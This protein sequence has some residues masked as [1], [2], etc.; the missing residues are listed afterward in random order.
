MLAPHSPRR[1]AALPGAPRLASVLLAT[2]LSAAVL[3]AALALSGCEPVFLDALVAD[4]SLSPPSQSRV[5]WVGHPTS[6]TL[7]LSNTSRVDLDLEPP[8]L[9]DAATLLGAQLLNAPDFVGSAQ[10]VPLE[11]ALSPAVDTGGMAVELSVAVTPVDD[12][13]PPVRAVLAVEV[14]TPPP[15][16]PRDP[17]ESAS[18]DPILGECVRDAH[19]DGES[20][21]D[22]SACTEEDRCSSGVCVGRALSCVDSVDCTIDTCDP[23]R[24][25]VFEPVHSRCE[26]DNPCTTDTCA[27]QSGCTRAVV[28]DGTPCGPFSC[29]QLETCFYGVCVAAPT[30]DGFPCEDG[31]LCT[32]GDS[33]QAQ[34]CVSGT[35]VEP[36]AQ[37]PARIARPTLWVEPELRW[38]QEESFTDVPGE[39]QPEPPTDP[40][41]PPPD[42]PVQPLDAFETTLRFGEALDL[43]QGLVGFRP[44]LVVLWKSEPFGLDG[45]ACEPWDLWAYPRAADDAAFCATA[46]VATF[47]DEGELARDEGGSSVVLTVAYG[48]VDGALARSTEL[49][50]LYSDAPADRFTVVLAESTYFPRPDSG[51]ELWLHHAEL[52]LSTRSVLNARRELHY[53]GPAWQTE[54]NVHAGL[55]V[56][57]EDGVPALV[58]WDLP[59]MPYTA[60][61]P[62]SGADRDSGEADSGAAAMPWLETTLDR[63]L[64]APPAA[65]GEYGSVS[66]NGMLFDQCMEMPLAREELA[67]R[68]VASFFHQGAPWTLVRHDANSGYG[69]GCGEYVEP[70]TASLFAAS[71]FTDEVPWVHLG[72]DVLSV[73][74][75]PRGE[76]L[77]M[78]R[79]FL[80]TDLEADCPPLALQVL[81][82]PLDNLDP[83]V[84]SW[85]IGVGDLTTTHASALSLEPR[86]G[87]QGA[88]LV[89]HDSLGEARVKLVDAIDS[90][91][92]LVLSSEVMHLAARRARA[93]RS[94][95]SAQSVYAVVSEGADPS[96]P[97]DDPTSTPTEGAVVRF[98]CPFPSFPSLVQP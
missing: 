20:C 38:S 97:S 44:T 8:R 83:V 19:P 69:G 13:V 18:F 48:T 9:G 24:G 2:V 29:T 21:S 7:S 28:D 77:A 14:R 33:C 85:S 82:P 52:E 73:S 10:S 89:E 65:P 11:V 98:G 36:S 80:C 35:P 64:I 72:D 3:T 6:V 81:T 46:V 26:D 55:R 23:T 30:P 58:G 62:D 88:V 50:E 40:Q 96:D 45:R 43:A 74:I 79:P 27:P 53:S 67:W 61:G 92:P 84:S 31:D 22:G 94:P 49:D 34:E 66:W 71:P 39:P 4:L 63:A 42:V 90:A 32:T 1:R 57:E 76:S 91:T 17:C 25:C 5:L 56:A 70:T 15:C 47:F 95:L 75:T 59:R 12:E 60:D 68:D 41:P 16:E 93:L 78:V 51:R 86:F 87:A 54:L 37:A